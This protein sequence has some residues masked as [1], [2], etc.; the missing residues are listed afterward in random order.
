MSAIATEKVRETNLLLRE[1]TIA[2]ELGN[3]LL[4]ESAIAT[5]RQSAIARERVCYI[6]SL[7]LRQRKKDRERERVW[8]LRESAT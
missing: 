7:L 5:E 1:S 4:R 3:L 8:T 6:E 2:R